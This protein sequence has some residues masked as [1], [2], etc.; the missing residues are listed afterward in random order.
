MTKADL[1]KGWL[2]IHKWIGLVLAVVFAPLAFSGSMLV[3]HET[4]DEAL[5]PQ[6]A[7]MGDGQASRPASAY[8]ADARS[9][10][11]KGYQITS[12]RFE[13]GKALLV[14]ATDMQL[15]ESPYRT[16]DRKHFWLD[17][18]DGRLLDA[19]SRDSGFIPVMEELHGSLF[20]PMYGRPV[21]GALGIAMFLSCASGLWLWWPVAGKV[22][23][24]LK[25]RRSSDTFG[26]VHHMAGFWVCLPLAMLALTGA[27]IAF[28]EIAATL[29]GT[30]AP[31]LAE[32]MTRMRA[33]PVP[34]TH[35]E[36]DYV[37]AQAMAT[38]PGPLAGITWPTELDSSWK[39]AI[40]AE[41]RPTQVTVDDPTGN[42]STG[43][44]MRPGTIGRMIRQMHEGHDMGPVWQT[45]IFGAGLFPAILGLTGIVMWWR[46][47]RW[48]V[49]L[50]R[51]AKV[52]KSQT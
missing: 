45:M 6:R 20:I 24:G 49:D 13:Q 23:R 30:K 4:L 21:I 43:G 10:F 33:R 34:S 39:V 32:R 52:A 48:R 31:S 26:N 29:S 12:M 37:V 14:T 28:P 40:G 36:V 38:H 22:T 50:A 51:R 27:W 35:L 15:P 11:D 47:R 8:L 9:H 44:G 25:W 7:I 5:N 3:W 46:S 19:R 1:R 16:L 41:E 2:Q 18:A 42:V 17:P